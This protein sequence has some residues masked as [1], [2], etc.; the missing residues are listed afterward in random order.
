M[1]QAPISRNFLK[2]LTHNFHTLTPVEM[3]LYISVIRLFWSKERRFFFEGSLGLLGQMYT[4]ERKAI[5]DIVT[6]YKPDSC[7]EIG[8]FTGGGS[9]YFIA[10][11]LKENG[12]GTLYTIE[13]DTH[14]YQK[15]TNYFKDSLP[16]LATHIDFIFA[17]TPSVFAPILEKTGRADCIFFDGAEDGVQTLEQYQYF[18]PYYKPGSVIIF[19]DW[20]TE[21]TRLVKDLVLGDSRW[22]KIIELEPPQS[23]GLAAF[24]YA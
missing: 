8:T 14:Y 1:L 6:K 5:F 19:H 9:T 15:A 24:I 10:S 21:K 4:A 17:D 16:A 3:F 13:N 11:A 20:N 18:V 7:Y 12:K 23:V 2:K 22:Q